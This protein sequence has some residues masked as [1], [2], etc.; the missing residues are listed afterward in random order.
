M[1]RIVA[2][3]TD[4]GRRREQIADVTARPLTAPVGSDEGARAV[5]PAFPAAFPWTGRRSAEE[6]REFVGDLADATRD[7]AVPDVHAGLD[8]VTAELTGPLPSDDV[9]PP[10]VGGEWRLRFG[11]GEAAKGWGDLRAE[12]PGNARRCFGAIRASPLSGRDPDRQPRLRGCGA[13]AVGVRGDRR[14][15]VR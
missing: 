12:E 8:R 5:L 2:D 6:V 15:G 7:V 14:G 10:P 4:N 3:P 1:A 13:A 9:P 11:T